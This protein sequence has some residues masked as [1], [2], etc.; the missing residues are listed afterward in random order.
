MPHLEQPDITVSI[1]SFNTRELLRSC[2]KSIEERRVTGD[3]SLQVVVADN[4]SQDGSLEMVA[5]EF[6]EVDAFSTGEN[7]GFGR[8]HNEAFKHA[9]GR[10]F[11]VL[12][13]DTEV[14]PDTLRLLRDF[15]DE[16]PDA[17]AA[18]AQL[19]WPDGSEQTSFGID[20][21]IRGIFYEQSFLDKPLTKLK[22][23]VPRKP[24]AQQATQPDEPREV[25][26]VCGACQFVR[27]EA[28]RQVE[29]YD[30]AFFMYHEDV[31]LNIRIRRAGW[32][33]FYVPQAIV[34]HH[35]GASSGRD[36]QVRAR[37]VTALNWSRYYAF[38]RD[39]GPAIGRL[40]KTMFIY[41]AALRL[42]IWTAASLVR[43]SARE[44]VRLF[45]VVLRNA[46]RMRPDV[47]QP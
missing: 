47:R 43:P 27:S 7:L 4:D 29:G 40:L 46:W 3:V 38:E 22:Q 24:E 8:A 32:R 19:L 44:K 23:L 17:G 21:N 12:N 36:W 2:L 31:D 5:A 18:G 14:E 28:Y 41:G 6:P 30:P 13:S 42:A 1:V 35:L 34:R 9:R 10:Y 33:I 37:M 11:F 15:M 45:R 16:H 26:Q 25:E 39:G 20:P